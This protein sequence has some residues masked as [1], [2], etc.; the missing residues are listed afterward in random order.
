M[1]ERAPHGWLGT[2]YLSVLGDWRESE[3]DGLIPIL[4]FRC[5]LKSL[6][7]IAF[8]YADDGMF[9]TVSDLAVNPTQLF[10]VSTQS[11]KLS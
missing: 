10:T 11:L 6:G 1:C 5:C 8:I 4:P 3:C 7:Y 9:V 2:P